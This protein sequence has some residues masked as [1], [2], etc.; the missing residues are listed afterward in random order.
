MKAQV[1][2]SSLKRSL[3]LL[4]QPRVVIR[5]GNYDVLEE[6][7]TWTSTVCEREIVQ[8]SRPKHNTPCRVAVDGLAEG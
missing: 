1:A 3:D 5:D 6:S 2:A 8:P 4:F 7:L